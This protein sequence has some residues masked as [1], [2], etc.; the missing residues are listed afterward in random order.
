MEKLNLKILDVNGKVVKNLLNGHAVYPGNY[1]IEWDGQNDN[2]QML[3]GG[4]YVYQIHNE[5]EII[6]RGKV[7]LVR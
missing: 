4:I 5:K 3:P 7:I 1:Q 6:S 2:G